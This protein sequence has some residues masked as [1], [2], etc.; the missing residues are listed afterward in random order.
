MR[1]WARLFVPVNK[2]ADQLVRDIYLFSCFYNLSGYILKLFAYFC[3]KESMYGKSGESSVG[4]HRCRGCVRGKKRT[5]TVY[6]P[7]FGSKNGDA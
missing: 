5:G 3:F 6:N 1:R 7:A 4:N 2:I